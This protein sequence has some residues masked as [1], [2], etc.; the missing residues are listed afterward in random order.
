[1]CPLCEGNPRGQGLIRPNITFYGEDLD[2][3]TWFEAKEAIAKADLLIV[4]GTSLQ[5]YP[6]ASLLD[7]FNGEALVL[8]NLEP[9]PCDDR[10]Q[11]VIREKVEHVLLR[12]SQSIKPRT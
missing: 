2:P 6:A 3:A 4:A 7:A 10:A 11:L 8:V 12:V 1:M 5:V 9:T